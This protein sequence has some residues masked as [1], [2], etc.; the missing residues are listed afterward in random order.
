MTTADSVSSNQNGKGKA[1]FERADEVAETGNW[2]YAIDLYL[3]GIKREPNN[4][5]RGHQKLR[6]VALKRK[7]RGGKPAGM[8]EKL[9]H[10]GG[11]GAEGLANVE[12]LLAKAPGNL[13]LMKQFMTSARAMD[14][15][16]TT[17][18]IAN[19]VLESQKNNPK[20][21]RSILLLLVD[22]YSY[23]EDFGLA[24]AACQMAMQQA[25]GDAQLVEL[26]NHLSAQHT[27]KAGKYD[28]E[29]GD[30]TKSVKDMAKQQELIQKD[31]MVQAESYLEQ[32]IR[33][34]R[35][36]YQASPREMGKINAYVDAILK[37]EDAAHEQEAMN[38]LRRAHQDTGAY[39]FKMRVGEI[40]MR[41]EERKQRELV[42]SGQKE[43]A[44]EHARRKLALEI[45]EYTERAAN[46]PTDLGVR[47]ELGVRQLRVGNFD[48]AIG[49]LQKARQDP[50]RALQASNFLGL[51][52]ARKGWLPEAADTFQ[53]ALTGE[54]TEDQTKS[55]RYNLGDVYEQ[56]GK[57][58]EADEQFSKVARTDF[59][60]R[61]V[62][63]RVDAIRK[64][65]QAGKPQE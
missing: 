58:A 16:E 43:A 30:F 36:E 64:K 11:K 12:F 53:Q 19:I 37:I 18:W 54:L 32:Q 46:Y 56:M 55:L 34:A 61:D 29:A 49:L 62:R 13:D 44:A 47:Y 17:G 26:Y 25:P 40:R 24:L 51:A 9:R 65:I 35:E 14:L 21:P 28:Q 60:Y 52:F 42:D 23:V 31:S 27:I 1:F 63:N 41:Q 8:V 45:E 2:D 5:A 39:Q 22:T 3:E 38:V 4:V 10:S 6:E 33:R 20:A 50:R 15:R 59:N 48:E 57:L 7:L